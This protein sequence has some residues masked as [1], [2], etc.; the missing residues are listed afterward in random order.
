[1]TFQQAKKLHNGDEVIAK[2]TGESI[3]VLST[4]VRKRQ[5]VG[6]RPSV[7]IKGNG[8]EQGYKEWLHIG[9]R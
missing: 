6:T 2:D 9:V 3:C 4:V 8:S 5:G 7:E 1:M